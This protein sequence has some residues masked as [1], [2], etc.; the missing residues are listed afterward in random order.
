MIC[1][2]PVQHQI[3]NI[4]IEPFRSKETGIYAS[5]KELAKKHIGRHELLLCALF[6]GN[7]F[8]FSIFMSNFLFVLFF[9]TSI[10]PRQTHFHC[11]GVLRYS[12]PPLLLSADLIVSSCQPKIDNQIFKTKLQID[13][14]PK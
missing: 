12:R 14:I 3:S 7:L 8:N 5:R 4:S 6:R 9:I 1:S 2:W 10:L 11:Q 13:I